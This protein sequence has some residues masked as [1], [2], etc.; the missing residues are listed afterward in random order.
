MQAANP[1]TPRPNRRTSHGPDTPSSDSKTPSHSPYAEKCPQLFTKAS[2]KT[3][4]ETAAADRDMMM[5]VI[6]E[7]LEDVGNIKAAY[8]AVIKR[9]KTSAKEGSDE[10]FAHNVLLG[11]TPPEF[12]GT[13]IT[14]HSEFTPDDLSAMRKTLRV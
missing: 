5:N 9:R 4:K 1:G 2:S 7:M 10:H 6:D 12:G 13:I 14:A 3:E 8:N 11:S